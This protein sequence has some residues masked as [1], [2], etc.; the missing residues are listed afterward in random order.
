MS[1]AQP[2]PQGA[3]VE[4]VAEAVCDIT[5]KAL[6]AGESPKRAIARWHLSQLA[7]AHAK[8]EAAL[9]KAR[10]VVDAW[11]DGARCD[12]LVALRAALK[13]CLRA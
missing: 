2:Q 12:A 7:A 1:N 11:H 8:R 5:D 10:A 4:S 9:E 13:E 6:A 3:E